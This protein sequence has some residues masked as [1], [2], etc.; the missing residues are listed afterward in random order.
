MDGI[1]GIDHVIVA[2]H[3]LEHA[4]TAWSRLGFTISPR[5][6]HLGQGTANYCIMMR[7]DYVE[8]LGIVDATDSVERLQAFL[9]GREGPMSVAF[10]PAGTTE[11]ARAALQRRQ[12]HPSE[13]GARSPAKSSSPQGTVPTPLQPGLCCRRT[14]P[15]G[16]TAFC[17]A[18]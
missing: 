4:R 9:A 12:L 14:K 15:W 16:S 1:R 10:A 3:D 6:R 11:E 13:P 5:G 8:L 7:S 17:A 2:V 18:T